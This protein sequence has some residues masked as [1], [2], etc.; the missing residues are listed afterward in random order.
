MNINTPSPGLLLTRR[1]FF[2]RSAMGLGAAALGSLLG[3]SIARAATHFAPRARRV[4]YLFMHGGP[5]Q[6]DLFDHKPQLRRRHGEDLPAS[7]RMDQRLTTMSA[8]Q[9][10]LPVAPSPFR[11]AQHGRSGAWMSALLPELAGVADD[12]CIV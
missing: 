12:L 6:L 11:F 7:I 8:N 1:H 5:S 3:E 2:A 9:K 10:T 4:I